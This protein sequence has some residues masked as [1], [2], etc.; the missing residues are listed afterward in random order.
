MVM[1]RLAGDVVFGIV[2]TYLSLQTGAWQTVVLAGLAWGVVLVDVVGL[3]YIRRGRVQLGAWLVIGVLLAPVAFSS[4]LVTGMGLVLGLALVILTLAAAVQTLPASQ[5]SRAAFAGLLAGMI[6]MLLDMF[7]AAGRM[8]A[9]DA[10]KIVTP[11]VVGALILAYGAFIIRRFKNYTL[12]GKLVVAFVLVA[13]A[14]LLLLGLIYDLTTRTALTAAANRTLAAGA[15]QVRAGLDAFITGNLDNI[16]TQA[17][18]PGFV[19]YLNTPPGLRAD[20]RLESQALELLRVLQQEDPDTILSYGLVSREGEVVLDTSPSVIGH[21]EAGRAYIEQPLEAGQPFAS[22][23][24]FSLQTSEASLYFSA[25]VF[26]LDGEILGVLR[27]RY[28]PKILNQIVTGYNNLAGPDSFA[29][30]FDENHL[31][32]AH[33]T[34]PETIFKLVAPIEDPTRLVELRAARRLPAQPAIHSTTGLAGLEQN[35]TN[36]SLFFSAKDSATGNKINQVAVVPMQTQPWLVGFFQPQEVFLAS[37]EQQRQGT[38]IFVVII[39][40][41]VAGTAVWLSQWLT[42]P[43]ARLTEV[44]RQVAAGDLEV[45]APVE[46]GDET[47]QLAQTFNGMT[48]QLRNLI[49]SLEGQVQERTAELALSTE[50]GQRAAAIR[51]LDT[52]LPTITEFICERFKLYY[53][54]VYFVDDIGQNVVLRAGSGPVGQA[55]LNRQHSLPVGPGSVAGL[56]VAQGRS[57][58]VPDTAHSDLFRPDP[59]LPETRSEM[60]VPLRIEERIIGVLDMQADRPHTFTEDRLT[61]FE[62]MATQLAISIDSSQKWALAQ[63]A[64]QRA[65]QAIKGLTRQVWHDQL[66]SRGAE[67]GLG[68]AYNLSNIVQLREASAAAGSEPTN[69]LSTPL[70]VQNQVIGH[71]S[72]AAPEDAPPTENERALLAAVAQR[73]SQKAENLRLFEATRQR[74]AREQLTRHITDKIRAS[75]DIERA[76]QIAAQELSVA[77]G[78]SRAAIDLKIEPDDPERNS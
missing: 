38:V 8:P 57:V 51:N 74:A 68:Y 55:L 31:H 33:G 34:A 1:T 56:V 61:V 20:S 23:V 4:L 15:E 64:R 7:G 52:L 47:G 11:L 9:P 49:G 16:Q 43:L 6:T 14:P 12:R 69:G 19:A 48:S 13:I 73:L 36:G 26:S 30:L 41:V 71:L 42:A 24:E 18:L 66:A 62:A 53:V 29:V 37:V 28:N 3:N 65:E 77:L 54:Q 46:T 75:R 2:F 76:L 58:V 10:L 32:L 25:P 35:L 59:L 21:I 63:D 44:A 67:T 5:V 72:A 22:P 40:V 39:S 45:Q 60:A 70:V 50:V 17:Q 78:T 27:A